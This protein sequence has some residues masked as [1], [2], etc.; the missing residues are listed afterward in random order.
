MI[1]RVTPARVIQ[2]GLKLPSPSHPRPSEPEARPGAVTVTAVRQT[3]SP[4]PAASDRA[5][6]T[7]AATAATR[8]S[9]SGRHSVPRTLGLIP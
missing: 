4:G 3:L 8:T 1:I 7:P 2:P 9:S 6:E 5:S